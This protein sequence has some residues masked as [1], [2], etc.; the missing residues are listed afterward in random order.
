MT[1]KRALTGTTRN[2]NHKGPVMPD[3]DWKAI[4]RETDEAEKRL[5]LKGLVLTDEQALLQELRRVESGE[6]KLT[7]AHI[8]DARFCIE[9]LLGRMDKIKKLTL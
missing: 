9:R 2:P 3:I 5:A 4:D 1:P 7:M 8:K 6:T